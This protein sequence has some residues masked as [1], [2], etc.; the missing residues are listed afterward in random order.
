[1]SAGNF[2]VC[3]PITL[4]HEGGWSDHPADPGGATMKGVTLAT[5]RSHFGA[6]KSKADLRAITTG[7]LRHIYRIGYWTPV[8]AENMA[9]GVDLAVF[10][11]AVNSGPGRAKQWYAKARQ[12]GGDAVALVR[13]VCDVRMGFLQALRTWGTFG[14]GWTRRVADVRA[15]GESMA[16]K[17]AGQTPAEIREAANREASRAAQDARKAEAQ[18]KAAGG[19]AATGPAIPAAGAGAEAGD[20]T[21]LLVIGGIVFVSLAVLAVI[22]WHRSRTRAETSAAYLTVAAEVEA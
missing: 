6:G 8:G 7:E 10:D 22:A 2:E 9:A 19:G 3:L 13:R 18:A 15:R 14:K 5:Y 1:M 20:L 21:T 12:S 16:R 17:A 11:A 4:K